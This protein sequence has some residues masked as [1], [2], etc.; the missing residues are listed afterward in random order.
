FDRWADLKKRY[1]GRHFWSKGY[2][3]STIGLNE[4]QIKEYVKYQQNREHDA[5]QLKFPEIL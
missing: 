4:E 2:C 3:V 5:E 1:W